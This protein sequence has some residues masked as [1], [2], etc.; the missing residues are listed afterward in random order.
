MVGCFVCHEVDKEK[1][2]VMVGSSV[3]E[4]VVNASVRPKME[5]NYGKILCLL[6]GVKQ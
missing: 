2:I 1:N 3:G 5:A 6:K 4:V